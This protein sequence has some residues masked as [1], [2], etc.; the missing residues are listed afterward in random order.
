MCELKTPFFLVEQFIKVGN[1]IIFLNKNS[2]KCRVTILTRMNFKR[3]Y[4]QL[5]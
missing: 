4:E 5:M 1:T 3:D 2:K